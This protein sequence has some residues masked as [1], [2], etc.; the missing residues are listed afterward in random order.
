MYETT[1]KWGHMKVNVTLMFKVN[2]QGQVIDFVF[3]VI[4]DF[5]KV[6]MDINISY[7]PYIQSEI[8]KVIIVY[9]Y[10]LEFEGQ[11]SKSRNSFQFFRYPR[12]HKY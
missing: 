12:P 1:D 8:W 3:F 2:F 11:P 5:E 6:R 10:D 9:I 7:V 4:I